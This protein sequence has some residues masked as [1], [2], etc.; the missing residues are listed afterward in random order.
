MIKRGLNMIG[1]QYKNKINDLLYQRETT[2]KALRKTHN[3]RGYQ[4]LL[5]NKSQ[6]G[7][8]NFTHRASVYLEED[9]FGHIRKLS[10]IFNIT[11]DSVMRLAFAYTI[12]T[13]D[14]FSDDIRLEA[15][16]DIKDFK[17]ILLMQE[18]SMNFI[19]E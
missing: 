7:D 18:Q 2:K 12:I 15:M 3:F 5:H 19:K 8:T 9:D 17:A 1:K 10:K 4:K 13:L 11:Q 14:C 6:T 16:D